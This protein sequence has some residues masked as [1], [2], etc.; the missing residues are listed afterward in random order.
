MG[1]GGGKQIRGLGLTRGAVVLKADGPRGFVGIPIHPGVRMT[2]AKR[3]VYLPSL[4]GSYE[5]LIQP[6]QIALTVG[7]G[8]DEAR[9]GAFGM[10]LQACKPVEL[11]VQ[12]RQVAMT[13]ETESSEARHSAFSVTLHAHNIIELRIQAQQVALT[14]KT[15]S[16][17]ARHSAFSMT[18]HAH[19]IIELLIQAEWV[20]L[21]VETRPM[22]LIMALSERPYKHMV[23]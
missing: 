14:L 1:G 15:G 10:T 11:L 9:H 4:K 21:T 5:L 17:E 7:T 8:S 3:A 16:I 20:A 12:A 13:L 2:D 18:L 6:K 22:K 23:L 19:N